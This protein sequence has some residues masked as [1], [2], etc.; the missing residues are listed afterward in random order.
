MKFKAVFTLSRVET[1]YQLTL[2]FSRKIINCLS[3]CSKTYNSLKTDNLALPKNA[4]STRLTWQT[5]NSKDTRKF[6]TIWSEYFKISWWKQT[7]FLPFNFF[8]LSSKSYYSTDCCQNF[9]CN[10]TCFCICSLFF[11]SESREN[12]VQN[13]IFWLKKNRMS[14]STS[15]L[16]SQLLTSNMKSFDYIMYE[17]RIFNIKILKYIMNSIK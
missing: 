6:Q 11:V 14:S 5:F 7:L 17:C 2:S 3:T 10:S 15:W 13:Q 9:L 16:L 8:F 4:G 1:I 12:L